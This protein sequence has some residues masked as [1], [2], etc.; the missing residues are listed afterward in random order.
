MSNTAFSTSSSNRVSQPLTA[1]KFVVKSTSSFDNLIA[2]A[3][4][5]TVSGTPTSESVVLG[6]LVEKLSSNSFDGLRQVSTGSTPLGTVTIATAGTSAIGDVS[7]LLN[8]TDGAT[9]TIGLA[10]NTTTYRFK[11]TLAAANDIKIDAT[12]T[13]T[14]LSFKK[15]LNGESG[16]GTDY[17]SGT[18]VSPYF[19]AT[20]STTVVTLTDKI[21]CDRQLDW[22]FTESA[23]NFAKRIPIGGING[24]VIATL[25][26]SLITAADPL[27]FSTEDHTTATLPALMVATSNSVN[28]QGGR[29]M[30]RLWSNN[31][32]SYKIQSSTDQINWTD[33]SEGTV[34][35]SAS[36]LTFVYLAEIT[37]FIRFIIT[38][39]ANTGDTI[40][41]ARCVY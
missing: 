19:V 36:T 31:S 26:S 9:L 28:V 15:A 41:D 16:A 8:P 4:L 40:L 14:M 22:S 5:G 10:G 33:T 2:L 24:T 12:A 6:N 39:N 20:V 37:D 30:L 25:T 23:S 32:I 17:Y 35:L 13:N 18:P 34:A 1:S 38:T 3:I 7:A 21:G 11:N 29:T 27:T